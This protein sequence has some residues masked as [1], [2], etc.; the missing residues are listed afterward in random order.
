MVEIAAD[1]ELN[2]VLRDHLEETQIH[3]KRVREILLRASGEADPLKCKVV[4]SLFDEIEE[5]IRSTA[6]E[7][8]RDAAII[9]AAQQVEHYEIS[10]YGS[11]RSYAQQLNLPDI[12]ELLQQTLEEEKA[13]DKKFS[14]ISRRLNERASRAA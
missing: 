3:A 13:A 9:L 2:K 12:A 7:P 5:L 6:H 4:Y 14:E 1:P 8:V 11:L 10:A